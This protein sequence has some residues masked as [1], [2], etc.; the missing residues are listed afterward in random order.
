MAFINAF[1]RIPQKVILRLEG[2]TSFAKNIPNIHVAD[3]LPQKD[4]LGTVTSSR[5]LRYVML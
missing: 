4:L 1:K 5:Y 2:D 3:W